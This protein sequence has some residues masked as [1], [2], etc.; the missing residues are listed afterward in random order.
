MSNFAERLKSARADLNSA[1]QQLSDY[2]N[3]LRERRKAEFEEAGG[4]P[5]CRG[6]GWIVTWDT[7]DSMSGCYAEYGPCPKADERPEAHGPGAPFDHSNMSKYDRNRGEKVE[8]FQTDAERHTKAALK[9]AVNEAEAALREAEDAAVPYKGR[10]VKVVRGRKV[11]KGTEG[12]VFWRGSS[13]YGRGLTYRIGLETA[14]G[15]KHFTA[16]SNVEVTAHRPVGR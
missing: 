5:T 4:C 16:E 2:T 6:R 8:L 1:T 7:M 11:P 14:E 12:R 15:D 3:E 10:T 9:Q 13:G